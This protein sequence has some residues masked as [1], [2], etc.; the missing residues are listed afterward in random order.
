MNLRQHVLMLHWEVTEQNMIIQSAKLHMRNVRKSK[1]RKI[2]VHRRAAS[3]SSAFRFFLYLH[4][5][6]EMFSWLICCTTC[7]CVCVYRG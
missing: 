3:V 7:V 6:T 4:L 1:L 5:E 2:A